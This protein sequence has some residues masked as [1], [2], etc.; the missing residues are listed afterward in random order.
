VQAGEQPPSN[1]A[2]K[3]AESSPQAEQQHSTSHAIATTLYLALGGGLAA[4]GLLVAT[5]AVPIAAGCL[6]L[7]SLPLQQAAALVGSCGAALLRAA[8]LAVFVAVSAEH[9]KDACTQALSAAA[10]HMH[11]LITASSTAPPNRCC[12]NFLA[13]KIAAP[14]I[15]SCVGSVAKAA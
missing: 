11:V 10:A 5:F 7:G 4:A 3:H 13:C 2:S 14:C 6:S 15:W 8:S 1:A 9:A 12:T